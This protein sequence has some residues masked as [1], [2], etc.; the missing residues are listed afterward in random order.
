MTR[1]ED[2]EVRSYYNRKYYLNRRE[3]VIAYQKK[4]AKEHKEH[5]NAMQ[6]ERRR[7]KALGIDP[8]RIYRRPST[9]SFEAALPPALYCN[10]MRLR[11]EY[12]KIPILDRPVYDYY[13][14]CKTIQ[15][16]ME[17]KSNERRE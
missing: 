5:I 2:E 6:R 1:A 15:Y 13:L 12:R 11:E 9:D 14:R 16:L 17:K 7:R 4:Y 3:A 10:R 8:P